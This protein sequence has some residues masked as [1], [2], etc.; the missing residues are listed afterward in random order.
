MKMAIK[1]LMKDNSSLM[2]MSPMM[3]VIVESEQCLPRW[4]ARPPASITSQYPQDLQYSLCL[5]GK[6][7][8]KDDN[9]DNYFCFTLVLNTYSKRPEF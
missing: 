8:D 7:Y 4:Q 3:G 1:I 9:N 5:S 6:D 2:I